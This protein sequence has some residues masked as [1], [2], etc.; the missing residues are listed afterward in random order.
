MNTLHIIECLEKNIPVSFS[1]YG[2]GEFTCANKNHGAN[3]DNDKYTGK[4]GDALIA[5]FKYMVEHGE[6]VLI[7][8][9][10]DTRTTKF[11][12]TLVFHLKVNWAN[13]HTL[14]I[15]GLT[16][17]SSFC[18]KIRLF[19]TIKYSKKKKIIVCNELLIKS[20]LLLNLDSL[21]FVPFNTWFDNKFNEVLQKVIDEIGQSDG[22]HIVITSCGMSA[23]VLICELYKKYPKGTYLDF[24]SGLDLLC[25]KK[26]SRGWGMS[27]DDLY[28]IIKANGLID[29]SWNDPKYDYIYNESKHKLGIHLR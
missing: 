25:T 28:T 21:V 18:D 15:T 24:G 10:D 12:E 6:N 9:W 27:Y 14:I 13:Y 29:D 4:L 17:D 26:D 22:N 8:H 3:C 23:K 11:W 16:N 7:G 19:R 2:D 1:K 20:K 5:S